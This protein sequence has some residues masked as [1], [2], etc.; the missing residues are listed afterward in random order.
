MLTINYK[1]GYDSMYKKST[2][3]Y[4]S[5]AVIDVLFILSIIAT[6][7]IPFFSKTLFY[8]IGFENGLYGV[9]FSVIL[10]HKTYVLPD[11]QFSLKKDSENNLE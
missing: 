10:F 2:T 8:L 4:I 3:H 6:I 9:H 11:Y 1:K 5:K 7:A